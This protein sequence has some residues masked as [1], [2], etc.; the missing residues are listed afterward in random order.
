M[1]IFVKV[2]DIV[3][4]ILRQGVP[5]LFHSATGAYCLGCGGTRAVRALLKGKLLL[6]VEC[7]TLVL[8][9]VTVVAME[10]ITW[11]LSKAFKNPRW[12]L[13]H[14]AFFAYLGG[15][16]TLINCIFKNYMLL[17]KGINL[18]PPWV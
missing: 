16:I 6:S 1:E 12:Y 11:G 14:E 9:G 3:K 17:V 2:A 8:Y 18:L 5:C 4:Q 15:I 7:H 13:G 10:L